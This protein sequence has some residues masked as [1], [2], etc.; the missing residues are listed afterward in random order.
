MD[1]SYIFR[2]LKTR[3]LKVKEKSVRDVIE[4]PE[5]LA[6]ILEDF[7]EFIIP[8]PTQEDI[9]LSSLRSHLKYDLSKGRVSI[10]RLKSGFTNEECDELIK[11]YPKNIIVTERVPH[12]TNA[13]ILEFI[14]NYY[15]NENT[16]KQYLVVW[17]RFI[18]ET[19][20]KSLGKGVKGFSPPL[21]D[22]VIFEENPL[23]AKD[24]VGEKVLLSI[25]SKYL[26]EK[27]KLYFTNFSLFAK[28]RFI[29]LS[30]IAKNSAYDRVKNKEISITLEQMRV[31]FEK[32]KSSIDA[33]TV[34]KMEEYED[35]IVFGFYCFVTGF[36][37][38]L[39][40]IYL[41]KNKREVK[42]EEN[43][44]DLANG[45]F[46]LRKY[47][48]AK[49]YGEKVY[50]IPEILKYLLHKMLFYYPD[51]KALV[52]LEVPSYKKKMGKRM[53]SFVRKYAFLKSVAKGDCV[54]LLGEEKIQTNAFRQAWVSAFVNE[55]YSERLKL[56]ERMGHSIV[57]ADSTYKRSF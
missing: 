43:C 28:N 33:G 24:M 38:D 49:K 4:D 9:R 11:K 25:V 45:V 31:I 5:E 22:G 36:R 8:T 13:D 32:A 18:N 6:E 50:A 2:R 3:R 44:I 47:K 55:D 39:G 12:F 56:A 51:K 30:S 16:K 20:P 27:H 35:L 34:K 52:G 41:C 53:N 40:N 29:E 15:K 10:E 1:K 54:P 14:N 26:K 37:D 21:F 17:N 7:K 57:E 42:P 23:C 19:F 48:T 46:H